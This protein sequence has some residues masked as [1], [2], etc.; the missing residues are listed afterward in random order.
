ML[1]GGKKMLLK[2]IITLE[3][4][5]ADRIVKNIKRAANGSKDKPVAIAV[6]G[7]AL[8]AHGHILTLD[9]PP[10]AFF[11]LGEE[12]KVKAQCAIDCHPIENP[13]LEGVLIKNDGQILGAI[14][15]SGRTPE[16]NRNLALAGKKYIEQLISNQVF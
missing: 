14:G 5:A 15:V 1:K 16:K 6:I 12:A 11:F 9:T 4:E 13:D 10:G 3:R 8:S 7:A 2:T